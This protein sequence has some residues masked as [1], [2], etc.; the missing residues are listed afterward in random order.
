MRDNAMSEE[1]DEA[2]TSITK[3]TGQHPRNRLTAVRV[4]TVK[5]PGRYGDGNGLY[6]VVDPS[7]AKRWI[8]RGKIRAKGKRCDLGLGSVQIVSLAD[9]R[10]QAAQ[11]RRDARAGK[12]PLGDRRRERHRER[13]PVP[14]FKTA[15]KAVHKE[16][17]KTFR[18]GKHKAQ[19]LASLEQYAFPLIGDQ[20]VDAL[21]TADVLK[22]LAPIWTTTPETA[23][24]VK[25]RIKVVFDWTKASGFRSGDNPTDGLK[26]VLPKH[27]GEKQHHAALP[28]PAVPAFI[29]VLRT[30]DT[31]ASVRLAF[32]LLILTATRTSE[33]LHAMWTEVDLEGK[34]WTIP[35]ARMKAGREHRV[36]LSERAIE[37]LEQ[38]RVYAAGSRYVFPGRTGELP[39][40]NMVFLM[41]LRR[42]QRADITVHGF[43]SSFRDWAGDKTNVATRVC[44]AALAHSVQDKTEAAYF[45]S[46]LFEQRRSLMDTWA[47][48]AT[49]KPADVV[50]IRA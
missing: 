42:L 30:A 2:A 16:Q 19:W 37:V 39:L 21:E 9:A 34:V 27:R 45:R 13:H 28:Y 44:E 36:P 3:P 48:F 18:N 12:D 43:R 35:G 8:W 15:A 49:A 46:D 14:T 24:R 10:D 50:S 17:A 31:S 25:Q 5:T 33:V 7:G 41:L 38:A 29:Q 6:L 20:R 4:R 11:F 1:R 23:R 32:E 40:S 22:V 47:K 26:T